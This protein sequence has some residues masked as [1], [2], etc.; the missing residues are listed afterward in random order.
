LAWVLLTIV[1]GDPDW[2]ELLG[3]GFVGD[4]GGEGREAVAVVITVVRAGMGPSPC[5]DNTPHVAA[6]IDLLP[7]VD[8]GSVVKAGLEWI[9]ALMPCTMLVTSRLL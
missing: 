8:C 7:K 6:F 3:I 9:L 2:F 4:V 5:F 1:L